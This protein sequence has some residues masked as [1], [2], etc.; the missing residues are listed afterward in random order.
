MARAFDVFLLPF[1]RRAHVEHER[2]V[3]A[4][5]AALEITD[6]ELRFN[7]KSVADLIALARDAA[8]VELCASRAHHQV[9][10]LAAGCAEV[11]VTVDKRERLHAG[12]AV[13]VFRT[14][15]PK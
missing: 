7:G 10:R 4:V 6:A 8:G 5:E 15:V 3:A 11:S 1:A 13:R 9:P 12:R 2:C 14:V